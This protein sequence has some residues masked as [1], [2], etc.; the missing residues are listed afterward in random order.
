MDSIDQMLQQSGLAQQ[1]WGI[2]TQ[3]TRGTQGKKNKGSMLVHYPTQTIHVDPDY[4]RFTDAAEVR[5]RV[6]KAIKR[7]ANGE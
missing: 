1:G 4:V 7:A 6:R 3:S 5:S 2:S